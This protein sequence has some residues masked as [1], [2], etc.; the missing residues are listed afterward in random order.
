MKALE[1]Q[2]NSKPN[3]ASNANVNK[4][5]RRIAKLS[6]NNESESLD[7]SKENVIKLIKNTELNAEFKKLLRINTWSITHEIRKY[8]WQALLVLEI[9][10]SNSSCLF[11]KSKCAY[12]KDVGNLFGHNN[13]LSICFPAFVGFQFNE[14]C[15]YYYLNSNGKLAV[16]R[17]LCVYEY[18]YPDV[19][20]SPAVFSITSILLHY[21]REHEVYAAIC[22]LFSKKDYLVETKLSWEASCSV[23]NKLLKTFCVCFVSSCRYIVFNF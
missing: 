18:N 8:L 6:S 5:L 15:N 21:L 4:L 10:D 13:E 12:N 14:H 2:Q 7:L 22:C 17:V 19:R 16:K 3:A 23:F 9:D 1:I 20:Y 11:E